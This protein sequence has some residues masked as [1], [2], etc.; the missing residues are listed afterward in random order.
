VPFGGRQDA[1][2]QL[3]QWRTQSEKHFLLLATPAGR[4]KSALLSRWADRLSQPELNKTVAV[5]YIP[6]SSRFTTNLPELIFPCIAIQ[7][8]LLLGE[9]VPSDY[10]N[11]PP[12][13]WQSLVGEYLRRSLPDGRPLLLIV[14]G[15]DEATW[16]IGPSLFPQDLPPTTRVVVSA[17][18][19]AGDSPGPGPW[20]GRLGWERFR[21]AEALSLE[22]LT[23]DGV[24]DV[25]SSMGGALDPLLS[26]EDVL[27]Q[28]YVLTRGDPLLV[29]LY[30]DWLHEQGES[31]VRLRPEDLA[32]IE[33]DYGGFFRYWWQAQERLWMQTGQADPME[34]QA[35][36]TLLS[37]LAMAL[38]PLS[39]SDLKVLF[40][41]KLSPSK[42][43]ILQA[44]RPLQRFVIG[45]GEEVGFSFSHPR[46]A[47]YFREEFL[48]A[49]ERRTWGAAF[50]RWG[51]DAIGRQRFDEL[52]SHVS[53]YLL[54][55][56]SRHLSIGEESAK[57]FLP[58]LSWEWLQGW[59]RY[60]GTYSGFLRDVDTILERLISADR[61]A[62]SQGLPAPFIG[63]EVQCILCHASVNQLSSNI[64]VELLVA[65]HQYAKW[66][67]EQVI[68]YAWQ[69]S[70]AWAR[71]E[72]LIILA[73]HLGPTKKQ[74]AYQ[75]VLQT[76]QGLRTEE[77]Q[78]RVLSTLAPHLPK[79]VYKKAQAL[80]NE[81]AR[82]QVLSA[83][84]SHLPEAVYEE[85]QALEGEGARAR[86]LSALAPHL[87][88]AVYRAAQAFMYVETRISVL[89]ALAP[90]LPD[91]VYRAA[92]AF[93]YV[94]D[95]KSVLSVLVPYLSEPERTEAFQQ[96]LRANRYWGEAARAKATRLSAL[97][98]HLP[99]AV[100]KEAQA[101]EDEEARARVLS[102]LIPHLS[103]PERTEAVQQAFQA[104]RALK[105]EWGRAEIL[106]ALAPYLPEAVYR[107]AEILKGAEA[108][109][110]VLSALAPYL[111]EGK[112]TEALRQAFQSTQILKDERSREKVL[113]AL[114]LHLP[115][116]ERA[117]ALQQALQAAQA[118]GDKETRVQVLSALIPHLSEPERTEA[119]QQ[120][121]QEGQALKDV[122]ARVQVLSALAPYLP[123]GKRT[124]ALRQAFQAAQ[125]FEDA[126]LRIMALSTLAPHLPEAAYQEA[127]ALEDEEVQTQVLSTLAP[128]LSE[129][130]RAEAFRQV[131]QDSLA[132]E[133]E[134]VRVQVLSVLAP[135]LPEVERTEALRQAFQE[136]QAWGDFEQEKAWALSVL[137]PHLPD[138]VYR[139]AQALED[140]EARARVLSALAPHLPEA[141]YQEAQALEYEWAWVQVL[142]ALAP[143]LSHAVYQE[144]QAL[145]DEMDRIRV[146]IAL[147]D[148]LTSL[149]RHMLY[150]RWTTDLSTLRHMDRKR[151]LPVIAG[152]VPVIE[153]LGGGM[154]LSQ[155]LQAIEDVCNWWP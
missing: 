10:I 24:R 70:F 88:E 42:Y 12:G 73:P 147:A 17:R 80:K 75:G 74:E 22:T 115:E 117:E 151:V 35:V 77:D 100:Y 112:R 66:T 130:E 31:T 6:I 85:A 63:R 1:L 144:A 41:A 123:E 69:K 29:E 110:Q 81:E 51:Q 64:P 44:L 79:V 138:A 14:D 121:F 71:V 2:D 137:A 113:S 82:A 105:D 124:E 78:A 11:M 146:L 3:E 86:V 61:Q 107:E 5:I 143:H 30:V 27:D 84:A 20:L 98:S 19:L 37:I 26:R 120:A 18:Y 109:I 59:H 116:P 155:T 106:S 104:V 16:E 34:K 72:A 134:E 9:D 150:A 45:D 68:S 118:L 152:L 28:L 97:A 60:T 52:D 50:I 53:P 58:L 25:L 8:A 57:S 148:Y 91:A 23:R 65:L 139:E 136:V 119:V 111:P 154:S 141:V 128:H 43:T 67:D 47:D 32:Q 140:E 87:P 62:V 103:E 21:L 48:D 99:E 108:W 132:L 127:R 54:R 13:F 122:W 135:Y 56:Y 7:L 49:A 15:L 95:R 93:M 39:T 129:V 142:S 46:L 149:P 102:A 133:N 131:F 89:S 92:Q 153:A 33:P 36:R 90:Y 125:A 40:P 83:L 96:A 38:G 114:A 4:G 101:L 126:R 94:E 145:E 55:Y 76:A